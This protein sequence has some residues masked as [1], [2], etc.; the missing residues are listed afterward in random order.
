MTSEEG[1]QNGHTFV[2]AQTWATWVIAAATIVNVGVALMQWRKLSESLS[3]TQRA[4][5]IA[6]SSR[7][8]G[9]LV[10]GNDFTFTVHLRNIG[11]T[12]AT[13]ITPQLEHAIEPKN[14]PPAFDLPPTERM[15]AFLIPYGSRIIT[16]ELES[17]G[18]WAIPINVPKEKLTPGT[19]A[20]IDD[21]RKIL[22]FYGI[23][24]YN[25]GFDENRCTAF[26][27]QL[28]APKNQPGLAYCDHSPVEQCNRPIEADSW[29]RNP[30]PRPVR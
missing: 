3:L 2:R 20:E 10:A 9:E 19:V 14:V 1:P 25:D 6:D 22:Y 11:Q 30:T 13:R 5:I 26:C 24:R 16:R 23:V 18:D 15:D 8:P 7:L 27:F 12:V 21:E 29:Y 17:T 4:E 28:K